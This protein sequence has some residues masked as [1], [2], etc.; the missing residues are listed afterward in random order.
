MRLKI[1]AISLPEWHGLALNSIAVACAVLPVGLLASVRPHV[2]AEFSNFKFALP[3]EAL[4]F[5]AV[6]CAYIAMQGVSA[7]VVSAI[8]AAE[9]L[10]VMSYEGIGT[11]FGIRMVRHNWRQ[12]LIPLAL[13][14]LGVALIYL[15]L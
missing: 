14:V 11:F 3:T 5:A 2:K 15:E 1:A 6:G 12:K 10:A 9:P 7:T 4:T 8:G 13:I